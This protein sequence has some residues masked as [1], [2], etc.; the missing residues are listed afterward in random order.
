[1][2]SYLIDTDWIIDYLKGKETVV[3]TVNSVADKGLAVS[4]IS[5]AELYEG[6]YNSSSPEDQ[7]KGLQNFLEGVIVLGIEEETADIFGKHK[8]KLRS[9]GNLIGNFDILIASTCLRYG[10]NLLTGNTVHFERI[11]GL[12]LGVKE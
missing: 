2:I 10:L 4:I 3:E 11:D 9:Q 7:R 8:S 12:V 6:V 5:I 1:V